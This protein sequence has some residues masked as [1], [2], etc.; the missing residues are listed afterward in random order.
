MKI[1]RCIS[2]KIQEELQDAEAYIDLAIEWKEDDEEAAELFYELSK[3]E[4]GH[5][6]KL[7]N[8]V[9]AEIEE[10]KRTEGEPPEG[11]MELYNWMHN[12][13]VADA[14]RIKVKHAMYKE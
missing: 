12:K 2:E 8:Q 7:H 14:L 6:E 4:M 3:E 13:N 10:Y 11:M 5:M 1:I 9:T